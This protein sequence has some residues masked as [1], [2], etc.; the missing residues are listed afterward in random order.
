MIRA[1]GLAD[2][3][4][5]VPVEVVEVLASGGRTTRCTDLNC[6]RRSSDVL[7]ALDVA[8]VVLV[9]P[10]ACAEFIK[11]EMIELMKGMFRSAMSET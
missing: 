2:D 4:L 10:D 5:E 11:F 9:V 1:A 6:D 3:E 8:V 7:P